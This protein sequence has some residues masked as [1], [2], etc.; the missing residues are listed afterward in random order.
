MN[1]LNLMFTKPV[2]L[3][4]C[5][6][7]LWYI[8]NKSQGWKKIQIFIDAMTIAVADNVTSFIFHSEFKLFQYFL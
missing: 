1:F 4:L 3:K 2:F 8:I 6:I 5:S 7:E